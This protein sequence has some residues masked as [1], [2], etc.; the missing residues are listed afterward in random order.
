M[1]MATFRKALAMGNEYLTLGGGE[2]TLHKHFDTMLLESMASVGPE[3]EVLVV[4]NGSITRRAL[5]LAKLGKAG[6]IA[7]QLSQDEYHDPIAHEVVEAFESFEPRPYDSTPG[8]RNTTRQNEPQPQGRAI[9][10]LGLEP[11]EERD[12][13]EC[14]CSTYI[15]KPDGTIRQCGCDDSPTVGNV[16]DGIDVPNDGEGECCHS[17]YFAKV[18]LDDGYEHLLV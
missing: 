3:G 14:M 16:D 4:T 2:P 7:S 17:S 13:F 1:S 12:G 18:C 10:L 8:V 15:V 6:V 5:T 9:E 11:P